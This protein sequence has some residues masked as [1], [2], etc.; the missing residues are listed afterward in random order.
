[1]NNIEQKGLKYRCVV[2]ARTYL[3][4]YIVDRLTWHLVTCNEVMACAEI[5]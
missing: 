5:T 1:M 2:L 3:H 4:I